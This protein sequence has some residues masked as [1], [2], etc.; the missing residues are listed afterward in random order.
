MKTLLL[1]LAFALPATP[2]TEPQCTA[3]V[4]L[5][6]FL[7]LPFEVFKAAIV[8]GDSTETYTNGSM[9]CVGVFI[10]IPCAI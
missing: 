5:N 7:N 1:L 6:I 8:V 4:P 3:F 2:P 10:K 9:R